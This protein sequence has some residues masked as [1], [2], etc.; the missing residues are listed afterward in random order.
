MMSFVLYYVV[1]SQVLSQTICCE[2]VAYVEHFDKKFFGW[3]GRLKERLPLM[4]II[5][6]HP[7][8]Q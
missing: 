1:A 8:P 2:P 7:L 6:G 4:L 5:W 3:E